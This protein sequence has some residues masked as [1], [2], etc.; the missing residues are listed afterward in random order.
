MRKIIFTTIL[1]MLFC[2]LSACTKIQKSNNTI[3][4]VKLTKRE[5][6]IL[7]TTSDKS[8]VYD[9]NVASNYK[10]LSVWIE[11]YEFGKLVGDK[12]NHI[13]SGIKEDGTI[14]FTTS[15]TP[16][17]QNQ[18]L[19]NISIN[20]DGST[21]ASNQVETIFKDGLEGVTSISGSNQTEN[22]PIQHNIVLASICYKKDGSRM[23]SLTDDFYRDVNKHIDEIRD[24]DVVYLLRADF[25]K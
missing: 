13:T 22:N 8:F 21:S 7:S 24:Y 25:I 4:E 20:S 5:N 6:A 19:F 16:T 17:N 18:S 12:I 3:S 23:D 11:K 1:I 10:E 9:F 2:S 14:I 15:K